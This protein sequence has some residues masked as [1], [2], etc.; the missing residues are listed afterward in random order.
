MLADFPYVYSTL[1]KTKKNTTP[2]THAH[3]FLDLPV[4]VRNQSFQTHHRAGLQYSLGVVSVVLGTNDVANRA[5]G[6]LHNLRAGVVQKL[7]QSLA[8][9]RFHHHLNRP[10]KRAYS[11]P[12][13]Q[14]HIGLHNQNIYRPVLRKRATSARKKNKHRLLV[15][16]KSLT[17]KKRNNTNVAGFGQI[18]RYN[19]VPTEQPQQ[20]KGL[21]R[22]H[23]RYVV[24]SPH[25]LSKSSAA[26]Y[27]TNIPTSKLQP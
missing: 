23:L 17:N 10:H 22:C 16:R 2:S 8:H 26:P 25:L 4:G 6:R 13:I 24:L 12:S 14:A 19:K 20:N 11:T 3:L 9:A 5:E 15:S 18:D 1:P 7:H 21:Q 27:S